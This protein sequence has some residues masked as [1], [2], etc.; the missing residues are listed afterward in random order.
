MREHFIEI[1]VKLLRA[2]ED[3][4][5]KTEIMHNCHINFGTATKTID[6]LLKEEMLEK[7]KDHYHTTPKGSSFINEFK[8]IENIFY[9]KPPINKELVSKK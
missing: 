9:S 6:T 8:K 4:T 5:S 7:I 1:V 2:A 3:E